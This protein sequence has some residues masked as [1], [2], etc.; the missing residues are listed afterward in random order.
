MTFMDFVLLSPGFFPTGV[1]EG[2]NGDILPTMTTSHTVD[3]R[4]I[5]CTFI[6]ILQN[7]YFDPSKK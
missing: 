4:A 5:K 1:V 3:P 7:A 6:L 2:V